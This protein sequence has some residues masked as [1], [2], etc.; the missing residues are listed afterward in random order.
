M[1][2]AKYLASLFK[3]LGL[4]I[5]ISSFRRRK[6]IQK[7][8]YLLKLKK[9]LANYL[10]FEYNMYFHGPY[11]SELADTYYNI[12]RDG[13]EP[14]NIEVDRSSME[15]SKYID[16]LSDRE[17]ELVTTLIELIRRYKT[18]DVEELTWLL[19]GIKP[20]YTRKDVEESLKIIEILKKRFKVSI[21]GV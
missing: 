7:L 3:T 19:K 16:K 1:N 10:P 18:Y 8:V 15:Y 2:K 5:D 12:D 21:D 14:I 6:R 4:S 17:L 11:S 20:W 9:E 13:V